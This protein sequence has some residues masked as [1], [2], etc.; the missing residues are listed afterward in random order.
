[1]LLSCRSAVDLRAAAKVAIKKIIDIQ[2]MDNID[3]MRTLREIKISRH[4]TGHENVVT[5]LDVIPP[6]RL[7]PINEVSHTIRCCF[8]QC[9]RTTR[10]STK[11][12]DAAVARLP[13]TAAVLQVY[14][15]FEWMYCDLSR[16][17]RSGHRQASVRESSCAPSRAP[18]RN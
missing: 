17:I 5:L 8:V 9:G 13:S 12:C 1:M 4:L 7:D 2:E 14:L 6:V 3:A 10:F 15:V 11:C 16:F 18:T